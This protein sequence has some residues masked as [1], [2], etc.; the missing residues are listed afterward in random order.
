MCVKALNKFP[1]LTSLDVVVLEEFE[2][3]E[4][5]RRCIFKVDSFFYRD[6]DEAKDQETN[7]GAAPVAYFGVADRI[8]NDQ[9]GGDT[10]WEDMLEALQ[11][12]LEGSQICVAYRKHKAQGL[13]LVSHAFMFISMDVSTLWYYGTNSEFSVLTKYILINKYIGYCFC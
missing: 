10:Q 4:Y 3:Y 5:A 13:I 2:T 7:E 9:W 12:T 1:G 11:R 6:P 8:S